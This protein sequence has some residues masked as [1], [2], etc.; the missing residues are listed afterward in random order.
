MTEIEHKGMLIE[1]IEHG[2][3]QATRYCPGEDPYVEYE[4]VT[5]SDWDEFAEWWGANGESPMFATDLESLLERI[6]N[7]EY[8]AI[9]EAAW[10][11]ARDDE[12]DFDDFDDEP[13]DYDV[14]PW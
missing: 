14:G 7:Q 6:S 11:K 13:I 8:D 5:V 10:D 12:P 1:T 9:S 4:S 3:E 2:G